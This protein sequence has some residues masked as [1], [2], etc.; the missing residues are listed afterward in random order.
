MVNSFC[1]GPSSIGIDIS[2]PGSSNVY[3]LPEHASSFSLKTTRYSNITLIHHINNY[4]R[5]EGAEYSEPY[6]LYNLD[7]A[8]Y[9]LNNPMALY[10]SIPFMMSHKK[11]FTSAVLWLNSAEMWID[12]EKSKGVGSM[13]YLKFLIF[14]Y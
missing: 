13:V 2:F 7:V 1:L 12:I 6:R 14:T 5:G 3:G 8:E 10:G 11:G 9:E 4:I